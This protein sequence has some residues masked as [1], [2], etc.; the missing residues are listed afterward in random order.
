MKPSQRPTVH[1]GQNDEVADKQYT[2]CGDK[3]A[4]NHAQTVPGALTACRSRR[5]FTL[6]GQGLPRTEWF[7][8]PRGLAARSRRLPRFIRLKLACILTGKYCERWEQ[9]REA[10]GPKRG[11]EH[12]RLLADPSKGACPVSS[13]QRLDT[14][15]GSVSDGRQGE[16]T[17]RGR[18][19]TVQ[20]VP[21]HDFPEDC[22][23]IYIATRDIQFL[24]S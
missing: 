11:H 7:S 8:L 9:G 17:R 24:Y 10:N 3:V 13:H 23:A 14:L 18:T 12:R 22:P 19:Q 5:L 4:V 16:R 21:P 2:S 15:P 6:C 20:P 1:T